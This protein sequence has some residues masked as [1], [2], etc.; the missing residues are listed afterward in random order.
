MRK[1][2][3]NAHLPCELNQ[4]SHDSHPIAKEVFF[5]LLF[6]KSTSASCPN[7]ERVSLTLYN[8]WVAKHLTTTNHKAW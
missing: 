7:P 1:G 5:L 3:E 2:Q 8:K 6:S 4:I